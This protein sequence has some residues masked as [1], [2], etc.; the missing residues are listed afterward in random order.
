[1]VSL[2]AL[3]TPP[4]LTPPAVSLVR[5]A[6]I[7]P[8]TTDGR[9]ATYGITY[10]PAV[11]AEAAVDDACGGTGTPL[12]AVG[13]VS[14]TTATTGGSL[15]AA[16][17]G[18]KVTALSQWGEGLPSAQDT[19]VVPAGTSTNTVTVSWPAVAGAHR[20]RVYG[21]TSGGPW[22]LLATVT[23]PTLSW[24]DTGSVT[25]GAVPPSTDTT[26]VHSYTNPAVAEWTAYSVSVLDRCSLMTG[27]DRDYVGRAR[28]L[29]DAATPKAVE[30]E[31][32]DGRWAQLKN[33]PNLYLTK[34]GSTVVNPTPGTAVS[35]A[36]GLRLLEQAL[37]D[38][39]FGAR[40]VIHL[41]PEALGDTNVILRRQGNLILT[42]LDNVVVPGAG[43][44][45]LGPQ[46]NAAE[47]PA[48]GKTWMYATGSVEYR[49]T[50]PEPLPAWAT[51]DSPVPPD[52]VDRDTNRAT[53]W[54]R[55]SALA[56]WD[57]GVHLAV[58]VDL[59]T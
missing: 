48:A 14:T 45:G 3:V 41:R 32:W 34:A 15:T 51:G 39:G 55:R 56:S 44:S 58:Y 53:L 59:P 16:T 8:D 21:R 37:A 6:S 43:Y 30:R 2:A 33:L 42:L 7:P 11:S 31:F 22:G 26:G 12:A 24:T 17:Y 52:A 38:A 57:G 54:L 13:T 47:I 9:W 23:V 20:Y 19:Q 35:F 5:A 25:P 36:R 40:G 49:E 29:L 50:P 46:G 10:P 27:F 18:Y 1:M 4:A 28:A